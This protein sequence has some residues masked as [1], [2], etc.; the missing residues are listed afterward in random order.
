MSKILAV[1]GEKGQV[2]CDEA[3]TTVISQARPAR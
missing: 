2:A 1:V 3:E